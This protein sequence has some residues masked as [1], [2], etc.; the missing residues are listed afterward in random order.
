MRTVLLLL[1]LITIGCIN[2]KEKINQTTV[3]QNASEDFSFFY[4]KFYSD[5]GFQSERIL[6]PLKG[7]IKAW[8][9]DVIKEESWAKKIVT[10]TPK[11][12]FFQIYKNLKTD[13]I[14]KDTVVIERYWIEQS[15][16]QLEK[17]YI[18]RSG[19]WYLYSYD[20]SNL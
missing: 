13:L 5:T 20:I 11:E 4:S 10:V 15:G 3:R 16:F 19:K 17:K 8:D 14:V 1:V 9:K 6:T 7:I 18:L 2:S 12:K